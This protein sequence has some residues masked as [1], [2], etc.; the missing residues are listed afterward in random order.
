MLEEVVGLLRSWWAG[1]AVEHHSTRWSFTALAAPARPV[2]DPLEIWL[3]GRGPK[4]LERVGRIADGWPGAIAGLFAANGTALDVCHSNP[5]PC[6]SL[7]TRS[8]SR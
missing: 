3:G 6:S 7:N 8:P 2:Q 4:A 5:N 1:E